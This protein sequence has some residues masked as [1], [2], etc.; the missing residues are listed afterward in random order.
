MKKIL[1]SII[2]VLAFALMTV[3]IMNYKSESTSITGETDGYKESYNNK[4][5]MKLARLIAAGSSA[6]RVA[7]IGGKDGVL[8]GIALPSGMG[9]RSRIRENAEKMAEE[10]YPKAKI[11]VEI[12]TEKADKIFNL[13]SYLEKGI[14]DEILKSGITYLLQ[15]D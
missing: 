6:K 7:V 5:N 2:A 14:P 11:V 8:I 1:F 15:T 3:D 10:Y 13:A 4:I 12:Q 9:G